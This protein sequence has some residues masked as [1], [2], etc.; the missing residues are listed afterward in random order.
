MLE[1]WLFSILIIQKKLYNWELKIYLP[2][3]KKEKN[4]LVSEVQI[5]KSLLDQ[6]RQPARYDATDDTAQQN[7]SGLKILTKVSS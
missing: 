4:T 7:R 2:E 5:K 3:I 1:P 6:G